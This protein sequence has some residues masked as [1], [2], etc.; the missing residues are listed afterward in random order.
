[1]KQTIVWTALPFGINPTGKQLR[2]SVLISP[3]LDTTPAASGI[4]KDFPDF[5]NWPAVNLRFSVEF[6]GGT[7]VAAKVTSSAPSS[8]HWTALFPSSMPV[9]GFIP[10]DYST[11]TIHSYPVGNVISFLKEQYGRVGVASPT[12][13]P[14]IQSLLTDGFKDIATLYTTKSPDKREPQVQ[15]RELDLEKTL[16]VRIGKDKALAPA[17]SEPTLDF[18]RA[19]HFHR[20]RGGDRANKVKLTDFDFHQ[21][22]SLLSS[23]P[24]LLRLLG[25]VV[26]LEVPVKGQATTGT[27]RVVPDHDLHPGDEDYTPLTAY[28]F[29]VPKRLFLPAPNPGSNLADGML[30]LQGPE[31]LLEQVDADGAAL[32][33]VDF[34]NQLV[35][36]SSERHKTADSPTDAGLPALRSGGILLAHTGRAMAQVGKF[37]GLSKLVNEVVKPPPAPPVTFFADDLLAG[38]RVDVE[39]DGSGVWRSLCEREV[40]YDFQRPGS[41]PSVTELDEGAVTTSLSHD[42]KHAVPTEFLL[43]EALFH[44][45]GWSL[46]APRVGEAIQPDGLSHSEQLKNPSGSPV[47]LSITSRVPSG[48]LPRLRFGRAYR[49]RVRVVDPAGRSLELA[50]DD[51][52]KASSPLTYRRF[53]PLEA[54][55]LMWLTG[56][57][58]E[59]LPGES[60]ARLVIRSANFNESLDSVICPELSERLIAP[61]KTSI[62]MAEQLGKLD[63]PSGG[64]DGSAAT[65][66]RLGAKDAGQMP[67]R[68]TVPPASFPYLPDPLAGAAVLR[69]LPG[70]TPGSTTITSFEPAS[71]WMEPKPFRLAIIEGTGAPSWNPGT[72]TLT[73]LLTKA[74]VVKV[75]L[76]SL[77]APADLDLMAMWHWIMDQAF[78]A[79][80]I[81]R[82]QG[83]A[84]TGGHWMLTP[85][86]ELTLVH[87][88]VQPLARPIIQQISPSRTLGATYASLA[89][90]VEVHGASTGRIDL[91]ASWSEPTGEGFKRRDGNSHAFE[92]RVHDP[93]ATSVS[94]D[95]R[96]H[97]LGDTKYR[98]VRYS[99]LATTRFREYFPAP[100]TSDPSNLQRAS[101][102]SFEVDLLS[103]ARPLAPSVVYVIPTFGWDA[104]ADATGVASRRR[105]G[106][107]VYLESPWF[108]SGDGELLGVTVWLGPK[109]FCGAQATPPKLPFI[110]LPF[111]PDSLKPY[112]TQ[113]GR[114]PI[115]ASGAPHPLPTLE[116]FPR[117]VAVETGLSLA[118]RQDEVLAVAGHTVGYDSDR[119]LF[120]ADLDLNVGEAYYPFIRLALARYQPCS[121]KDAELSRIVLADFIQLASD[122]RVWIVREPDNQQSLA[123]TVSGAGYSR[124]A[125]FAC[126]SQIEVRIERFLDSSEGSIG[127]VPVSLEPSNLLD[128]QVIA[129]Q[130]VWTGKLELPIDRPQARF[131]III[132]EYEYFLGDEP[133]FSA[134]P[135]APFGTGKDRRLVYADVVE[136]A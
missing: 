14:S 43:H 51:A 16:T 28:Q 42:A 7:L 36:L 104:H 68:D 11:Q 101:L 67:E 105:A 120:Y 45:D 78:D 22:L 62:T 97:E 80:D 74:Q 85:A 53:E 130:T 63:L 33:A 55:V 125:S 3:R 54:P 110:V 77:L 35:L 25:L 66:K 132:E 100:A 10:D 83:I 57:Q 47:E 58:P 56:L 34:A 113:W 91:L 95:G 65:W 40:T 44:W 107:R 59:D 37:E 2:L 118:E 123:I 116:H 70:T 103:T 48:T 88:V 126:A 18:F 21:A 50:S 129:G 38:Y 99:A 4:L 30:N 119:Q 32:K 106:L 5:R 52:S 86:R 19:K 61:P 17:P 128:A 87:A 114:D 93:E 117:A 26:D 49:L 12:Q 112:A 89:G 133:D 102:A 73:V 72:R 92:V 60:M 136:I 121:V 23:H 122:R 46:S 109:D 135:E 1:M 69:K 13:V 6:N 84:G 134:A 111:L 41:P 82:L 98:H 24:A 94:L 81:S 76:S 8:T 9:T 96:R 75:R 71:D 124:N 20:F 131:R 64:V 127:W 39:Q 115:W 31:F 90:E 79:D 108:S 29:D 27:L 15:D